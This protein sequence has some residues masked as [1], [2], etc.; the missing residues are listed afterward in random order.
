MTA[1]PVELPSN[2]PTPT[3]IPTG[4]KL[5]K[6][7]KATLEVRWSEF[8]KATLEEA[9]GSSYFRNKDSD[10]IKAKATFDTAKAMLE[11]IQNDAQ[12]KS[13]TKV[14]P[15]VE[16]ALKSITDYLK[17]VK[18]EEKGKKINIILANTTADLSKFK[19]DITGKLEDQKSAEDAKVSVA[20]A[21]A[22]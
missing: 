10:F 15:T 9:R 13:D 14:L 1:Q 6:D 19:A 3:N 8:D 5:L 4:D 11:P 18:P 21:I 17:E 16:A 2:A 12:L 20:T 22:A 7:F